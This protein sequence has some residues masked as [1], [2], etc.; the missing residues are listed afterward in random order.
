MTIETKKDQTILVTGATGHQG[1]AV[2]RSLLE[3][4]WN[5]R[6]LVRDP[7]KPSAGA[8]K[9]LGIEVQKGDLDVYQY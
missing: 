5:V 7:S 8:L 2:A 4:G 3:A 6:A 1:G 9:S